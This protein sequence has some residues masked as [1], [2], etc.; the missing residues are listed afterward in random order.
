[1]KA[2]ETAY[3]GYRFRSRLEAR[4][5][6]YFDTLGI[7]WEYEREGFK[8]TDGTLYLPDFWLPQVNMWAEVK[9]GEFTA[10]EK[11]KAGMLSKETGFRCL[12]LE[13]P[14]NLVSYFATDGLEYVLSN[15]YIPVFGREDSH[16]QERRFFVNPA[17]RECD[18]W[19]WPD[20][21][22]GVLA[23]RA[24]RFEFGEAPDNLPQ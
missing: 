16:A 9:P 2:I 10:E 6:V 21:N 7:V 23:A 12:L 15:T 8:F 1:M 22:E 19:E 4:W 13:G 11:K 18:V 17:S 3:Q 20:V 14:P 24:A 5:A